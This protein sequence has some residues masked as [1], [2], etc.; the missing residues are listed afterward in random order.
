MVR[1]SIPEEHRQG[2]VVQMAPLIDIIFLIL[3]FFMTLSIFAQMESELSISVPKASESK[4][5]VRSPGEIIINVTKEGDVFVNQKK[6][7]FDDLATMLQKVSVLFPNQPVIIRADESTYHKQVVKVL[8]A[9]AKAQ[10][11]DIS[12]STMKDE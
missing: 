3:I 2:P 1:L 10:I 4:Q 6:L 11:W 7:S 5:A 9:C 12:I 8:D